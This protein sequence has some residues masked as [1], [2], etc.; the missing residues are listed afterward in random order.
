MNFSDNLFNNEENSS[1][2]N[3]ELTLKVKACKEY[4]SSGQ[5]FTYLENIE[6]VIQLCLEYD[7]IEDGFFLAD[8]ALQIAPYN[9]ELW[10]SKGIFLNSLFAFDEALKCFDKAFSLN[11]SDSEI[12]I[13]KSIAEENL[14]MI[15]DSIESL[16]KSL[17]FDPNNEEALFS[18]ATIYEKQ[19]QFEL[20]IHY[21]LKA[22]NIDKEYSDAWYELGY[23]YESTDQLDLSLNCYDHYIEI[24][25]YSSSGWY[26]KGIVLTRLNDYEKAIDSFELALAID[27]NLTNAWFNCGIAYANINRLKDAYKA[28]KRVLELDPKDDL[29]LLNLAKICEDLDYIDKAIEYYYRTL[30][31]NS[32]Y[33]EAFLGRG[34]CF[35]KK[36][37]EGLAKKDF[38]KALLLKHNF[39]TSWN[40]GK[41]DWVLK[42]FKIILKNKKLVSKD[43]SNFNAWFALA[44]GYLKVGNWKDGLEAYKQCLLLQPN[45]PE[46]LYGKA[47]TE[48]YLRFIDDAINDLKISFLIDPNLKDHFNLDFPNIIQSGLFRKLFGNR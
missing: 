27:D 46:A 11:P 37:I 6:E 38:N 29:N 31:L 13:N 5:A 10:Y 22:L 47:V 4:I 43:S 44:Q 23:C 16:K 48:F 28:F 18:I 7:Y 45:F 8:A 25:P 40:D 9:S 42:S 2:G 12:L 24:E 33:Y 17:V 15:E 36:G 34:N 26:N 35:M 21:F 3:Q 14:G 41:S 32:S 19:E 20:A 1:I 39:N 30:K